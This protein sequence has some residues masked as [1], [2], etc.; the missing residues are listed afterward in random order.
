MN[1]GKKI[2]FIDLFSGIGGF[3]L[4]F[5]RAGGFH[6]VWSCDNNKWANKIYIKRFKPNRGEHFTADIEKMDEKQ[7]PDHEILTGGFPCQP[8]SYAGKKMGFE[9]TRGTLFFEII[10]IARA[11]KPILLLLENVFG[12]LSHDR[13]KTFNTILETLDE[14]GY[15]AEWQVFDSRGWLPQRRR[16][17]FI[18]GHLRERPTPFIF[19][20]IE[21]DEGYSQVDEKAPYV[22]TLTKSYSVSSY[23]V[24]R[25]YII[26]DK[27]RFEGKGIMR[28]LTPLE[29]ERI[30]GFPDGWTSGIP[31]DRRYE[32]L[33]NAVTVNVIE[34][35]G[36]QIIDKIFSL[37]E[38]NP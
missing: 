1:E 33:G 25:T 26:Y 6:C 23:G 11:K 4:G 8:F 30:Q 28:A 27:P 34:F 3:R 20:I 38:S 17:I 16:R 36:K 18:M 21:T 14:L 13:G 35:L 31:R 24:A 7:I 10:K 37:D 29:C 19:P 5:E 32:L 12:L 9:D 15:D 2:R 22:S